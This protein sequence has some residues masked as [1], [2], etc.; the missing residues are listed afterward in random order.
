MN[1]TTGNTTLKTEFDKVL[2]GARN[3]WRLRI[4]LERAV[5]A[6]SLL[7]IVG[8]AAVIIMNASLFDPRVVEYARIGFFVSGLA[9]LL[10]L[11]FPTFARASDSAVARYLENGAPQLDA[12]MLSAVESRDALEGNSE[13]DASPALIRRLLDSAVS[14][15]RSLPVLLDLESGRIHRAILSTAVMVTVAAA[16]LSLGPSTWRHGATLLLPWHG[17]ADVS[18]PYS[19]RVSPGN[20]TVLSGEDVR[21]SAIADGFNPDSLILSRRASENLPWTRV[22]LPRSVNKQAFETFIF[23]MKKSMEYRV[24]H[25]ALKSDVFRIDVVS[26]PLA[27]GIDLLYQ[28]PDYTGRAPEL[29][30]D[31]GD[32]SAVRGTRVEVRVTPSESTAHGQLVM[33]GERRLALEAGENGELRATIDVQTDGRYR[34][35]LQAGDYGMV[36]ASPEYAIVAHVDTLPRVTLTSPGRDVQVTSVEEVGIEVRAEDDVAVRELEIVLSVNGGPDEVVSLVD[37]SA[38]QSTVETELEFFLEN[39]GL[40]PGDL[41]A[42]HVRARDAPGD[43]ARQFTSDIYFMDVRPFEMSYRPSG[44]AGGGGGRAGAQQEETLSAQQRTLVVAMFKLARD[45]SSMEVP[46]LAERVKTLHESQA[47]IRDRVEAIVR[48]L[49]AR[50]IVDLNPGYRRMAEEL[51]EAVK[52]MLKVEALLAASDLD[53]SLPAA[54][55]A[56]LHLQRAESAFREVQVAQARQ[57]GG[58]SASNDLANLFRLEMDR[59]RNQYEDI[60]RGDWRPRNRQLDDSLRK[61]RELAERQQRELERTRG[62]AHQGGSTSDN[63]RALADEVERLMRELQRLS[64]EKPTEELRATMRELE[65]AAR[66]MRRSADQGD[67]AAGAEALERLREARRLLDSEIPARLSR[68]TQEALRLAEKLIQ[69]QNEIER[70]ASRGRAGEWGPAESGEITNRKR[71][72]AGDVDSMKSRLDEI[73]ERAHRNSQRSAAETLKDAAQALREEGLAE[74][75]RQSAEDIERKGRIGSAEDENEFNRALRQL[76]ERVATAAELISEPD[77]TRLSR[78]LDEMRGALRGLDR[79]RERLQDYSRRQPALSGDAARLD[80]DSPDIEAF[81]RS[82]EQHVGGI[83]GIAEALAGEPGMAGDMA[84][85]LSALEGARR[86]QDIDEKS[87]TKTHLELMVALKNIERALRA[88]LGTM[89]PTSPAIARVEPPVSQREIVERYYRNLSEK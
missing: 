45:R 29:V 12:L 33:D 14:K 10:L 59:F 76:R 89:P 5:V 40:E 50:S 78:M 46:L 72:L 18:N 51:P 81:R 58:A 1:M 86:L 70:N 77:E 64:R 26:R 37:P 57:R 53:A 71:S 66:A 31:G 52:F 28:F 82:L 8:T 43:P 24:E 42:Y 47:R 62:R 36:P 38:G 7:L 32:I 19:I 56:L 48:R 2:S 79:N 65:N 20:S 25:E 30:S 87:L 3:R 88:R 34:V 80:S 83:E 27:K 69:K 35:E 23:D 16:L 39:R 67:A 60:R 41:I 44:G 4:I 63:Q 11:L 74:R 84:T 15:G 22:P 55:Y 73:A 49:G 61:L 9:A 68:D 17:A 21:I 85:L 75:I 13:P 54:R 6:V